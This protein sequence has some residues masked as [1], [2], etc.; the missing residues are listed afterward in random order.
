MPEH[1]SMNSA[2][3]WAE[4]SVYQTPLPRS[5]D[6]DMTTN[7]GKQGDELEDYDYNL[8]KS[9]R[10]SN[11]STQAGTMFK[12]KFETIEPEPVFEEELHGPRAEDYEGGADLEQESTLSS[13]GTSASVDEEDGPADKVEKN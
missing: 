13:A 12:T 10:R 3:I 9:R 4:S 8:N 11:S 7:R 2:S 6:A 1:H 5:N